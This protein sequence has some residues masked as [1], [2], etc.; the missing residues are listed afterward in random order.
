[1]AGNFSFGDYFKKG[2]IDLAWMLLTGSVDEGGYG[3]P[4]DKLWTTVY[5]DDDEAFEL[6]QRYIPESRIQRR[7][8]ADNYWNMG[9][10]GPVG[11]FKREYR[12]GGKGVAR[13]VKN[14]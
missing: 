7:D 11:P 12:R 1:M 9:V 10:P 6:W 8:K 3:P 2:A 13:E 5:L 4:E 14:Q